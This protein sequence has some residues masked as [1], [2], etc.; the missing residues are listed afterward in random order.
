MK[1]SYKLI[2]I[3]ISCLLSIAILLPFALNTANR[4]EGNLVFNSEEE[5][6]KFKETVVETGAIW[7]DTNDTNLHIHTISSAP[8]ILVDFEVR[9]DNFPY[10]EIN[11][12]YKVNNIIVSILIPFVLGILVFMSWLGI[13]K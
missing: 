8:P 5:Y 10:G 6:I 9:I 11:N 12:K 1:G 4:Y 3:A 2:I 7:N 13:N